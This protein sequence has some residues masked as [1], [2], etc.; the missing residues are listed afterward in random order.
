MR[1][2]LLDRVD[3]A[4]DLDF[5]TDAV[6]DQIKAIAAAWA[7]DL[8]LVGEQFGTIGAVKNGVILE[9]TTFRSEI[10]RDDSRKPHVAFSDDITED[11]SRRDF[12]VNAMA[13]RLPARSG[14]EPEMIDPHGG[15]PD[16]FAGLLRTPLDPA[17]SFGDDPLRMLRLF[18]FQVDARLHSGRRRPPCGWRNERPPSHRLRRTDP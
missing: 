17:I 4:Q 14:D 15:L 13:L 7:D 8:Y 10:Y 5:T 18:R 6:P 12:A 2:A 9:I 3:T 1:D 11:L 16:L